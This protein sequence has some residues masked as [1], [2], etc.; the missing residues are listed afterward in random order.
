VRERFW[1]SVAKGGSDDCWEWQGAKT[2]GGYGR[3]T[4]HG[5]EQY[6]HRVS[7]NLA[8]GPIP[9]GICVCHICD[10]RT[11]VNPAHLFL[12]TQL[13]N[14]ADR[15]AKGRQARGARSGPRMHPERMLR[16]E[17]NKNARLQEW[18]IL[19]IRTLAASGVSQAD[20][21]RAYGVRSGTISKIVNGKAWAHVPMIDRLKAAK[22]AAD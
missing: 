9:A 10:N 6:A 22:E 4:V 17:Q 8:R 12:G 20:I 15:D 1:R 3:I 5:R 11:C 2:K 13:E 14:I 16:G 21:A 18:Q 7:W 19:C